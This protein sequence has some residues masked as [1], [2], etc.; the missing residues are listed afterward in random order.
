M[1]SEAEHSQAFPLS[2]GK[3]A[4][5]HGLGLGGGS[6]VLGEQCGAEAGPGAGGM[7]GGHPEKPKGKGIWECAP[8]RG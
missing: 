8:S 2:K 6:C 7:Q 3:K 5:F 4:I 1:R